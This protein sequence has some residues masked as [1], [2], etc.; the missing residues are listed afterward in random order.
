MLLQ[1]Q[2]GRIDLAFLRRLLTDHEDDSNSVNE[3][4]SLCQHATGW[5]G[6]ATAASFIGHLTADAGQPALAW[7]AFGAPCLGVYFPVFLDGE[8]PQGFSAENAEANCAVFLERIQRLGEQVWKDRRRLAQAREAFARLQARF[9]QETE[10]FLK[11][12]VELKRRGGLSDL[13]RQAS[14]F[15]EHNLEQF[16]ETLSEVASPRSRAAVGS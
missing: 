16:E 11:E 9:E 10:E 12:A 14:L 6:S 15:M 13:Q 1:E 2:N 5:D 8:L 3:S 7:C 4:L